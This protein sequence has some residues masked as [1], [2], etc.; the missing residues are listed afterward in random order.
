MHQHCD[1]PTAEAGGGAKAT[2]LQNVFELN[3]VK[4]RAAEFQQPAVEEDNVREAGEE[5]VVH[6]PQ[7][8]PQQQDAGECV[9]KLHAE[10]HAVRSLGLCKADA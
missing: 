4:E 3:W 6:E 8:A 5:E 1:V 9:L 2:S 10:H 7:Q